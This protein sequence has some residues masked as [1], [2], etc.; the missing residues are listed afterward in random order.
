[1]SSTPNGKA[2]ENSLA[3]LPIA[4]KEKYVNDW[5]QRLE[6]KYFKNSDMAMPSCWVAATVLRLVMSKL[7]L[8]IYHPYQRKDGGKVAAT[9]LISPSDVN[10]GTTLPQETK[11]KLFIISLENIESKIL[12]DMEPQARKWFWY[13]NTYVQWH[14]IAFLLSELSIRTR[15]IA[16]AR[17]WRALEITAPQ[18]W[19]PLMNNSPS[20]KQ[21]LVW[22]PIK[23]LFLKA[24]AA[25]ERELALEQASRASQSGRFAFHNP[26]SMSS[27]QTPPVST[28]QPSPE[29]LDSLL[30]PLGP[31]LGERSAATPLGWPADTCPT[32]TGMIGVAV[33]PHQ[34]PKAGLNHRKDNTTNPQPAF[35]DLLKYGFDSVVVDVM[36]DIALD[37]GPINPSSNVY[38]SFASKLPQHTNPTYGMNFLNNTNSINFTND[39]DSMNETNFLIDRSH[40]SVFGDNMFPNVDMSPTMP[41]SDSPTMDS[42]N[43]DWT[44]WDDMLNQLG[45]EGQ[46]NSGGLVSWF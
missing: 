4:D 41:N 23:R 1:M 38:P 20:N 25:R 35:H 7:W 11:D 17:A 26:S 16:V 14:A 12:L 43:M 30:R 37:G 27:V 10:A 22:K 44:V 13:F 36:D 40:M 32:A 6:T 31:R 24:R 3:G 34:T 9:L 8:L 45:L 18:W 39:I 19:S 33:Q 42:I 2:E 28:E 46:S 21:A 5:Y 29:C 15:G